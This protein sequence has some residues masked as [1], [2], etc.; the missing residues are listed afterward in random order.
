MMANRFTMPRY[1]TGIRCAP[2]ARAVVAVTVLA[3]GG[4]LG[5]NTAFS[6]GRRR[7]GLDST[8]APRSAADLTN[9]EPAEEI[10]AEHKAVDEANQRGEYTEV[11]R[12]ASILIAKDEKDY[13]A[14]HLRASAK[15]ELGRQSRDMRS[16]REGVADARA[17]LGIAGKK[18]VW[19]FIPYLYGMTTLAELESRPEH[20]K[21]GIDVITPVLARTDLAPADRANLLYQRGL[22]YFTRRE[23][24]TA[25]VDFNAALAAVSTHVGALIKIGEAY[26]AL[27]KPDEALKAYDRAATAVPDN[28]VILNDR[29]AYRRFRGNLQGA[30]EDF[31][32]C[33]EINPNFAMGYLNRGITLCDLGQYEGAESDLTKALESKVQPHLVHRL[34]GTAR[35]GRG[36]TTQGLADY[37]AAIELAPAYAVAYE[38]RG[39][40]KLI[41]KD[42]AG[43][44]D[45]FREAIKQAPQQA[46]SYLWLSL[47]L[48]R[49]GNAGESITTLEPVI[50]KSVPSAEWVLA[51]AQYLQGT[52]DE[53]ALREAVKV[54]PEAALKARTCEAEFFV[55]QKKLMAGETAGAAENFKQAVATGAS[56]LSAHRVARY[57]TGDVKPAP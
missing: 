6:Q 39:V 16:V 43:A 24:E 41:L 29:G 38:D 28:I 18:A 23:I 31:S 32:K 55:G 21:V 51:L 37:T 10:D 22:A 48:G 13:F 1:V 57:E 45:D 34:R 36:L 27:N 8:P 4:E 25:L 53:A 54:G 56:L 26:A 52:I 15:I 35:M 17:A 46:N 19:L 44:A 12:L 30:V 14:L 20:A 11:V 47:A 5:M 9:A 40:A 42:F 50:K 49:A 33:L 2:L 3:V 7:P